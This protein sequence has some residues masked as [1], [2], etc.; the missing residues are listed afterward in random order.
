[1]R[2]GDIG[3]AVEP[4]TLGLGGQ[5]GRDLSTAKI[6]IGDGI[7]RRIDRVLVR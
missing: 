6:F 1:M 5:F 4:V 2:A 3:E 7:G